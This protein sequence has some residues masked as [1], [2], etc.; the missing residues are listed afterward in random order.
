ME[1]EKIGSKELY[2]L[3]FN[4]GEKNINVVR[5]YKSPIIFIDW[6]THE[7]LISDMAYNRSMTT[8][9]HAN[10]FLKNNGKF[11]Y[12]KDEF[13]TVSHKKIL[14]KCE[15]MGLTVDFWGGVE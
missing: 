5:S 3:N 15:K 9:R 7:F 11:S 12:W 2:E 8:T 4:N 6:T 14:K 13:K 10:I 1:F